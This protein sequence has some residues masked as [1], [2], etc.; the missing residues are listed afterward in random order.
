MTSLAGNMRGARPAARCLSSIRDGAAPHR[1]RRGRKQPRGQRQRPAMF[2][3]VL[4]H[5]GE[6]FASKKRVVLT[7]VVGG[8]RWQVLLLE[9]SG[10]GHRLK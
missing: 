2:S 9:E 4:V 6:D 3:F 7:S 10:H 1:A 8:F 5:P